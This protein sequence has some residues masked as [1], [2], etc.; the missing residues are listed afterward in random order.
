MKIILGGYFETAL[1]RYTDEIIRP[2][3]NRTTHPYY[4]CLNRKV[5]KAYFDRSATFVALAE[6]VIV[7][8]I[9]WALA[10]DHGQ[11]SELT[12]K[13]MGVSINGE[14]AFG[15]REWDD[16]AV[17]FAKILLDNRALSLES[18]VHISTFD[19]NALE[20]GAREA[21]EARKNELR[22]D[23]GHHYLCRLLLQVRATAESGALLVL[24]E[25]DRAILKEIGDFLIQH[26]L[27]SPYPLPDVSER[28][29]AGDDFAAGLLNFSPP[30]A[31][32]MAAV[33]RDPLVQKYAQ[34][35]VHFLKDT[36]SISSQRELLRAMQETH[37][38]AVAGRKAEKV[39]EA[40]GWCV[41]PLHYV[42]GLGEALTLAEDA[43]DA[44]NKWVG[45]EAERK[46][47]YLLGVKMQDIAV[48]DYLSRKDNLLR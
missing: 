18:W 13:R 19:L 45:R 44:I 20:P 26:R 9:D 23:V 40:M 48:S 29:I 12:S 27:A 8:S 24:S 41:K 31:I 16:D 39:F 42:P 3:R 33:K 36:S 34:K 47:W 25:P 14:E 7:P 37:D 28:V 4:I 22:R 38:Q 17:A 15:G 21:L 32:A 35:V 43:K 1:V 11:P 5:P 6:E 2:D 30:D 46:E 10:S